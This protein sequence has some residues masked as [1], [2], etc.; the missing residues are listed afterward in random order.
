MYLCILKQAQDHFI[1]FD[2][3]S[4]KL[5]H[6]FYQQDMEKYQMPLFLYSSEPQ[7]HISVSLI[8]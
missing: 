1:S 5:H 7:K 4:S 6:D 2:Q 3:L 8:D